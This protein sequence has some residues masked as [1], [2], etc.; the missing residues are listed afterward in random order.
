MKRLLSLL[1][2]FSVLFCATF[3][4]AESIDLSGLSYDELVDL[5][6]QINLAIWNSREWQEVT[7]PQGVWEVGKDIPAGHWTIS[8]APGISRASVYIGNALKESGLYIDSWESS[9]YVSE[10]LTSS[11]ST[12]YDAFQDKEF[13]SIELFDGLFV[14]IDDSSVIF[15][16][17]AGKPDLGFK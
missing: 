5:K 8:A 3:V 6:K 7:V 11:S 17:F 4:A 16:P 2:F 14:C 9:F 15:T 12:D 13:F 1:F 10:S